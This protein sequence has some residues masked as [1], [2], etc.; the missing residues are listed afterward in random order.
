[1]LLKNPLEIIEIMKMAKIVTY[2]LSN[3]IA[4]KYFSAS[5]DATA[6]S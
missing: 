3:I 4:G 5:I 1:L 6:N 2:C